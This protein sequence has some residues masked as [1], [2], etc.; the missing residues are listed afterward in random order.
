LTDLLNDE[1][2]GVGKKQEFYKPGLQ[3]NTFGNIYSCAPRKH[4]STAGLVAILET[5]LVAILVVILITI[6][7]TI[8][9]ASLVTILINGLLLFNPSF[10][11]YDF[12][13]LVEPH[14]GHLL[15]LV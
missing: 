1:R 14:G 3:F 13:P 10:E 12:M 9:E 8:L 11:Q 15:E 4:S 7:I 2:G 6:L 5:C